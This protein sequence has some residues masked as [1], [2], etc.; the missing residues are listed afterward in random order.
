LLKLTLKF[1]CQTAGSS[2]D[3]SPALTYEVVA[4]VD[5]QVYQL[6]REI[7]DSSSVKT[8]GNRNR[9]RQVCARYISLPSHTT[10]FVNYYDTRL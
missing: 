9:E 2:T 8:E 7:V 4:I 3:A 1:C 10:N 5:K 6:L